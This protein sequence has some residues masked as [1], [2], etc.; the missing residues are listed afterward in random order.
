MDQRSMTN[1]PLALGSR[2]FK[3]IALFVSSLKVPLVNVKDVQ[4]RRMRE[5]FCYLFENN[6]VL[7]TSQQSLVKWTRAF[8]Q[9][10]AAPTVSDPG[11]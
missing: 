3:L 11:A 1:R 5:N 10:L 2:F 7:R 6:L 4:L 9:F 8:S